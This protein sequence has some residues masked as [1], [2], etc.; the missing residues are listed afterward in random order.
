MRAHLVVPAAL[1]AALCTSGCVTASKLRA[2][3][4]QGAAII[5]QHVSRRLEPSTGY[6]LVNPVVCFDA[7]SGCSGSGA[8]GCVVI[9]VACTGILGAVDLVALP[10][11]VARRKGQWR[12]LEVIGLACPLEDPVARVAPALASRM[13]E[14]FGFSPA[15]HSGPDTP[16]DGSE[17]RAASRSAVVLKV[18][19]T[20]FERASKVRWRGLVEFI[21]PDDE[22]LWREP[23]HGEAPA[24]PAKTFADECEAARCEVAEIA[25]R[26]VGY[27][28]HR[29]RKVWS[30]SAPRSETTTEVPEEERWQ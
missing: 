24:R 4:E 15:T 3:A 22:V 25:D 23:C 16:S 1:L 27:V 30:K 29:L 28:A 20:R 12:D 9:A 6:A 13:I 19:T 26:C 7:M 2:H 18:S 21:G 14:E 17:R 10:M 11:Q 8:V 5:P